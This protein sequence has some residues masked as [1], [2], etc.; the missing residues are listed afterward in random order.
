MRHVWMQN[1]VSEACSPFVLV[2]ALTAEHLYKAP[3]VTGASNRSPFFLASILV[4]GVILATH[5][6]CYVFLARRKSTAVAPLSSTGQSPDLATEARQ[7][8]KSNWAFLV[9][10]WL[11]VVT[12]SLLHIRW[13]NVEYQDTL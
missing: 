11:Y 13:L 7:L 6:L 12:T 9:A 5:G 3:I 1:F 10:A 2:G 8:V 4:F